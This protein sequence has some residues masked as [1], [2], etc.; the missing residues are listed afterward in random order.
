MKEI[1]ILIKISEEK[2][3]MGNIIK[4][5]G[6]EDESLEKVLIIIGALENLKQ[7]QLQKLEN[8]WRNK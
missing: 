4:T 5:N 8:L 1:H 6:F 7:Q 3:K 2:L